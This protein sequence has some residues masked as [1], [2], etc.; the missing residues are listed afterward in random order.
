MGQLDARMSLCT[1]HATGRHECAAAIY[2]S[3]RRTGTERDHDHRLLLDP[4]ADEERKARDTKRDQEENGGGEEE[5][6]SGKKRPRAAVV[7]GAERGR[8]AL[9]LLHL[10]FMAASGEVTQVG[11]KRSIV[12]GAMRT[13]TNSV[14]CRCTRPHSLAVP[15]PDERAHPDLTGEAGGRFRGEGGDGGGHGAR[16]GRVRLRC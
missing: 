1:W 11:E 4:T 9:G 7:A 14:S 8:R 15:T 12:R 6:G 5:T 16:H 13:A 2:P 10:A 3:I